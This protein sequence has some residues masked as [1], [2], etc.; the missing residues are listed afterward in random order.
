MAGRFSKLSSESL[1]AA[2][3]WSSGLSQRVAAWPSHPSGATFVAQVLNGVAP[4]EF[5]MKRYNTRRAEFEMMING[6]IAGDVE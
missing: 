6:P 4:S 3:P 2:V 1:I 5:K